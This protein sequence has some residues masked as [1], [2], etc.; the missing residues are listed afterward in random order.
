[1][2][3]VKQA[4]TLSLVECRATG[5]SLQCGIAGSGLGLD[6]TGVLGCQP[7]T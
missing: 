7:G 2:D 3:L 6:R 1:M 5:S 4:W